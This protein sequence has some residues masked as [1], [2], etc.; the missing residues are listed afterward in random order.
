[1]SEKLSFFEE[2]KATTWNGTNKSLLRT[3]IT[4]TIT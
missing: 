4:A 2:K 1:M 3:N